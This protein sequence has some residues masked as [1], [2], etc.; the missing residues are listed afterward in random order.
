MD[1]IS[2]VIAFAAGAVFHVAAKALWLKIKA[3]IQADKP[4][5]KV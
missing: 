3:K 5:I 4:T 1:I 2:L